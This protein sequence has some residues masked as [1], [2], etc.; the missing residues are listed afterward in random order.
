MLAVHLDVV[1]CIDID[2]GNPKGHRS[3][4]GHDDTGLVITQTDL[5]VL[6]S[7]AGSCWKMSSPPTGSRKADLFKKS[8]KAMR[9]FLSLY[10][11]GMETLKIPSKVRLCSPRLPCLQ[12]FCNLLTEH[13]SLSALPYLLRWLESEVHNVA[14]H[15]A[16]K[17]MTDHPGHHWIVVAVGMQIIVIDVAT[18][19]SGC[20]QGISQTFWK[21]NAIWGLQ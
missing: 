14:E 8:P 3:G 4:P 12:L 17:S 9:M 7:L 6:L 15:L 13:L 20:R 10:S 19:I 1:Q 18:G 11:T 21:K 5:N 16:S 2:A